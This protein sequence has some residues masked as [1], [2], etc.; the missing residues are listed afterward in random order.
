MD[1]CGLR[2]T[3]ESR[4]KK[5]G[6]SSPRLVFKRASES[7][8]GGRNLSE[9][10]ESINWQPGTHMGFFIDLA[11]DDPTA[12]DGMPCGDGVGVLALLPAK[13]VYKI[14]VKAGAKVMIES[15][16][17]EVDATINVLTGGIGNDHPADL[18]MFRDLIK[19]ALDRRAAKGGQ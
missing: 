8:K 11:L 7:K 10:K 1:G 3:G 6:R 14:G 18:I 16:I 9:S 19:L 13:T 12:I 5:P 2:D 17:K 15:V 4:C